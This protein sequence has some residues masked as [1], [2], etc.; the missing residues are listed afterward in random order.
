MAVAAHRNGSTVNSMQV[1]SRPTAAI[2][3]ENLH[4]SC[5]LTSDGAGQPRHLPQLRLDLD[6]LPGALLSAVQ[7]HTHHHHCRRTSWQSRSADTLPSSSASS[8][9][10]HRPLSAVLPPRVSSAVVV[11]RDSS[12]PST[13]N[14]KP[15]TPPQTAGWPGT[16]RPAGDLRAVLRLLGMVRGQPVCRCLSLALPLP[17]PCAA[18]AFALRCHCL[19]LALPLPSTTAPPTTRCTVCSRPGQAAVRQAGRRGLRVLAPAGCAATAYRLQ[20]PRVT[21]ACSCKP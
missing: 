12:A 4:C 14:L 11:K 16:A 19:S 21:P 6:S 8:A 17:S 10:L 7:T 3:I 1:Q 9:P 5:T 15:T 20:P 2:P 13:S 18:T